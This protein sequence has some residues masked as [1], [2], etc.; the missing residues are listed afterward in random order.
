MPYL[1]FEHQLRAL[2]P[3]VLTI[4]SGTEAIWRIQGRDLLPLHAIITQQR[5]GHAHIVRGSAQATIYV[6][7]R[8]LEGGRGV[9]NFGDR[10][11]LA[12]AEFLYRQTAREGEPAPTDGFLRDTR[13][14]RVYKLASFNEI[15]RDPKC[16]VMIQ[17]PEVSRVHAEVLFQDGRYLARPL[18]SAYMLL[19]EHRLTEPAPL[20][21][22]DELTVGRTVLRFTTEATPRAVEV[23]EPQHRAVNSR[24]AKMQTV[25]MGAVEA[26]ERIVRQERRKVGLIIAAIVAVS[27]MIALLVAR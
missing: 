12:T 24:A 7:G 18:G 20:K 1:E 22:G 11:R 25:Y 5:D 23:V 14:G 16:A 9:L 27:G 4:G 15:G 13:R 17:E 26:R 21:E 2:G 19:N 6:N 3:G 8:E 10:L